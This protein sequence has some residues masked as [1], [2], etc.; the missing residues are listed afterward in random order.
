MQPEPRLCPNCGCILEGSLAHATRRD[1]G[2]GLDVRV[3][4]CLCDHCENT[5][6]IRKDEPPPKTP[7]ASMRVRARRR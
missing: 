7:M 6:E 3:T 1:P 2:T 4:V 5:I